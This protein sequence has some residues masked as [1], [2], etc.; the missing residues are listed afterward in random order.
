MAGPAPWGRPSAFLGL[1]LLLQPLMA[2]EARAAEETTPAP[3]PA[4]IAPLAAK[5]L[6]LDAVSLEDGTIVAVGDRGDILRSKDN[7]QHWEQSPCPVSALLT[8]I[9]AAPSGT[10]FAVGHDA[11]IL[12]SSDAGASWRIIHREPE[13]EQP[14]FSIRFVDAQHGF[15]IGAYGL[16]LET[17]NGGTSWEQRSIFDSDSHLYGS[18]RL[19]DGTLMIVGEFGTIL[20]SRD[21]GASWEQLDSPYDGTFFGIVAPP[22]S[23]DPEQP[24]LVYGLQG[25]VFASTDDGDSWEQVPTGVT[26]GLFGAIWSEG[27]QPVLVGHGGTILADRDAGPGFDWLRTTRPDREPL[28][29]GLALPDG[30]LLIYGDKGLTVLNRQTN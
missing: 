20:R 26:A 5:S 4:L 14:L 29:G 21:D 13:W 22:A 3:V 7:G 17:N 25:H 16:Y 19:A 18:V 30:S 1:M 8:G 11:V 2:A 23:S 12:A 15:A 10:L 28:A 24:L 6:I 9:A 27:A